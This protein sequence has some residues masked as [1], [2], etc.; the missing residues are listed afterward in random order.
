MI[1]LLLASLTALNPTQTDYY[2]YV[3]AESSDEVFLARFDGERAEVVERIEVG[4][5]ATEI[6][7]PHGLTV[8]PGGEHWYVSMAHGKPFGLLY[9]YR[10]SDNTLV[11]EAELGLFPATMQISEASG[12]LY[13]VNFDLHG[14]MTPSS[15]SVVDFEEMVEV[16][17]VTTGSMP[18]GSRLSPDGTR[19]YSCAMMT[20]EVYEIDALGFEVLRTLR[21][22][23]GTGGLA[24]RSE[25]EHHDAVTKPTWIQPHPKLPRAYVCLNGVAQVVEVDLEDWRITRRFPTGRG[26]YNLD[27]S[28]DGKLLTV[29]YKG[30]A[31]LGVWDL[32]RGEE[33]E[34]IETSQKITHGVVI[35]PDGRYAFVSCEGVG[36]ELGTLEIVDLKRLKLVTSLELGLQ[37]GGIAFWKME[38]S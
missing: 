1:A 25:G 33:L 34:R 22:S 20:D 24:P 5:M 11:G 28:P 26:P 14:D 18:H 16:E 8:E 30:S 3:A 10:T 9:K 38:Q 37:A 21:L 35:S 4:F 7:G 23:D 31:A 6:E 13:C 17:R 36:A 27:V 19:H 12:L 2:V 15:V 32:G 29:T